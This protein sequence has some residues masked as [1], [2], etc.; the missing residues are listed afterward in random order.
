MI[1]TSDKGFASRVYKEFL[2]PNKKKITQFKKKNT[3]DA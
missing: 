1:Y 3:K 2:K